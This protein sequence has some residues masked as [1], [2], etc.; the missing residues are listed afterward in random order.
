MGPLGGAPHAVALPSGQIDI[1][2]RG[3]TRPTVIWAAVLR[4]RQVSG[5]ARQGGLI[6][7]EISGEP[8]PVVAAGTELILYQGRNGRLWAFSRPP[9]GRGAPP[10]VASATG[11]LPA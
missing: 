7:G 11:S 1:F 5:P 9:G 10:S 2:W 4:G 8:W 6:S 3:K